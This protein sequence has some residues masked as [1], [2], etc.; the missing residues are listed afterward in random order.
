VHVVFLAGVPVALA[1]FVLSLFLKEV[2]L[3]GTARAAAADMGEG[4]AMPESADADQGLERALAKLLRRERR[5]MS[6]AVLA[7][8]P[9][10]EAEAWCVVKVHMAERRLGAASV[11]G[12]ADAVGVPAKVLQPAFDHATAIGYVEQRPD[13]LHLTETGEQE[14]GTL[15]AAWQEWVT[16]RLADWNPGLEIDLPAAMARL[17]R[18]LFDEQP[19][20]PVPVGAGS[21]SR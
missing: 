2:P 19:S 5:Q 18:R 12:I 14:F 9:L 8:S 7:T 6:V 15:A 1:A 3:R 20:D 10:D 17:A 13:G 16:E 11:A 21:G 4:F